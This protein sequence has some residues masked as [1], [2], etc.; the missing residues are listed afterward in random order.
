[1]I[2]PIKAITPNGVCVTANPN[3]I[4]VKANGIENM[5]TNGST[6][7]SNWAAI[8]MNTKMMINT[9]KIPKS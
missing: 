6:N 3:T 7:D 4:P 5:I 9:I 2:T 8:T 1:M